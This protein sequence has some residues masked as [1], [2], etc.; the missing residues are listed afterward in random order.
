[1]NASVIKIASRAWL[2]WTIVLSACIFFGAMTHMESLFVLLSLLLS[3]IFAALGKAEKAGAPMLL[4]TLLSLQNVAIGTGAHLGGNISED[5]S[6][7]TQIPFVVT[8]VLFCSLIRERLS[9]PIIDRF[10][11]W[12]IVLVA[13][14]FVMMLVGGGSLGAKLVGLRNLMTFFMVFCIARSC[15]SNSDFREIFYGQ[16]GGL[17][18]IV[19]LIGLVLMGQEFDFWIHMGIEEVYIAK[20]APL[21]SLS[22]WNGRFTTSIDG[23]HSVVRMLSVYYEPVNLAYLFAAGFICIAATW[24][25]G[26]TK[27]F[28]LI[29]VSMGLLLTFGKGGWVVV[30]AY[31]AFLLVRGLSAALFVHIFGRSS[32]PGEAYWESL[33]VMAW[34]QGGMRQLLWALCRESGF[35]LAKSRLSWHSLIKLAF[36][37]S[38]SCL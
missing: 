10:N 11:R 12:F 21:A 9:S 17:C 13:W 7:L 5:L 3:L 20:Q 30:G 24:K 15:L 29:V 37:E 16:F 1:M 8:V 35:L 36:L 22:E 26:V 19:T 18:V 2:P 4:V 25:R 23:V 32:I 33:L 38:R 31:I 6:L 34:G 28:S 27:A 14:V